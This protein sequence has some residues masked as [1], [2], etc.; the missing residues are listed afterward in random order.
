MRN[1]NKHFV[2]PIMARYTGRLIDANTSGLGNV[3]PP[4]NLWFGSDTDHELCCT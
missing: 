2:H 1:N 4:D 3:F